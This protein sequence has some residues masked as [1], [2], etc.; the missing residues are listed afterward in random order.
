VSSPARERI[1]L[2]QTRRCYVTFC[3]IKEDEGK[4]VEKELRAKGL[5]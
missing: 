4:E 5:K 1:T 2:T 3:D